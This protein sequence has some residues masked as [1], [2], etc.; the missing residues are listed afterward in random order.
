[1]S[2][3][4]NMLNSG[5]LQQGGGEVFIT[6]RLVRFGD[7]DPAGIAYYPRINNFIH[8][9]FENLWEEYIGERY[10]LLIQ[11]KRIAFPM[12]HTEIDF[13]APL[14]FGDRPVI[15]V[16]C[17]HLGRSSLGIRYEFD[18]NGVICVD[19]KTKTTCIDAD[20]LKSQPIPDG[21][22]EPLGRIFK[23]L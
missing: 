18:V 9:A 5:Q 12:V 7:V 2:K 22:R 11:E 1:M 3:A 8:E 23:P 14:R 6:R 20:K 16:T 13:R 21:Y 19:A 17:F 4:T 10:Y 15:K